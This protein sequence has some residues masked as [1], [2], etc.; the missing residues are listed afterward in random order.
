MR[1]NNHL[2]CD[3]ILHFVSLKDM[4]II[5]MKIVLKR[6]LP[7]L[8]C[9]S[10]IFSVM[11]CSESK[12]NSSVSSDT[13]SEK[14]SQ[15]ESKGDTTS[16]I[17]G[18]AI[19]EHIQN[20]EFPMFSNEVNYQR[21]GSTAS[22]ENYLD[23]KVFTKSRHRF[24]DMSG[25]NSEVAAVRLAEL[26]VFEKS[27]KFSPNSSMTVAGFL[28]A[29]LMV[30][31]QD[32]TGKTTDEELKSFV[33]STNL[34]EDG[35][36][37]DYSA[38]LTNELL[39][40]LVSRCTVAVDNYAQYELLLTDY[41]D[42]DEKYRVGVLQTVA[43]GITEIVDFKFYPKEK[44]KRS[45]IADGLYRLINTGARVIPL[46]DLG[47]LYSKGENVYLV[48]SSYKTNESGTQFGLFTNYNKQADAFETFGKLPI[49]RTGFNKW[50]PIEKTQGVYT[51]PDFTNDSSPHRLGQTSII[52]VDISA[53]EN[54]NSSLGYTNIPSF[55]P[56]DITNTQ[57][58]SAAKRFLYNFVKEMLEVLE[59][60]VLLLIDYECDWQQAI[61]DNVAGL[62]RAKTFSQWFVEACT[63]A[64]ESAKAIGASDR[65]KLG[66]N[67]NNITP[68]HLR[69]ISHN[70]WM[71]DMAECVD[72]VTIDS[73]N[74]YD[75]KTDPSYTIQ[76]IRFLMNNYSL[77]KPVMVV[78]NGLAMNA[79]DTVV[80]EITGL[81]P[82]KLSAT[83]FKNL[84]NEF[85]FAL[86]R[87]D[88]LNANLAGFL[89][90]SYYDT[91]ASSGVHHGI[92]N[93]DNTLRENGKAIK[94]GIDALYKQNQFNPSY[95]TD[96]TEA[97]VKATEVKV[98]SGTEYEK[99]TYL[100]TDY[101]SS[102]SEG[103]LRV[104][105]SEKGTVFVSVNGKKHF[106]S[107]AVV[108]S[109]VFELEGLRDGLN[110]IDI[111][112]GAKN[113]PSTRTVEKVLFN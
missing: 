25:H 41:D 94:D 68:T 8:L 108:D 73:Y 107:A 37:L 61:Y 62:N 58:R 96:V 27:E 43:I 90:W 77:G 59:G 85:K 42:I 5:M 95:L 23:Y 31:Q 50:A 24:E 56:R 35:I 81:T 75:D 91:G 111:Y 44:A 89:V 19:A 113:A 7:F 2:I 48:K 99:L 13:V 49:D 69:G 22:E 33:E 52:C 57:T 105:I 109:H 20:K 34:V 18:N 70:K 88:F 63:V 101:D 11:G 83:Y 53:H 1:Y 60:D 36:E 30:C 51:W 103:K 14:P 55:Y 38:T 16:L 104:K 46:Y 87:G 84:F 10:L 92:V 93:E 17:N 102:A 65:L 100:I 40:Y 64:R 72:Y 47:N 26:G 39:A 54:W 15:E 66:V 4:V 45:D 106:A 97:S 110:V 82:T 21:G 29:L 12:G 80:D 9:V 86:E 6:I 98:T 76:N 74:F 67:Y 32:V 79:D 78:E 28:K 71:L 3:F 112:F